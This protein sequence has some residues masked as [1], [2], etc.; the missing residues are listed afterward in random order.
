MFLS[1]RC[2][3][4]RYL[5][6]QYFVKLIIGTCHVRHSTEHEYCG[7]GVHFVSRD[8]QT[9]HTLRI[10]SDRVKSIFF[11]CVASSEAKLRKDPYSATGHER[12]VTRYQCRYPISARDCSAGVAWLT[13]C[14]LVSTMIEQLHAHLPI[15]PSLATMIIY[16]GAD[17]SSGVTK[18]QCSKDIS[19]VPSTGKSLRTLCFLNFITTLVQRHSQSRASG[20]G[21]CPATQLTHCSTPSVTNRRKRIYTP[22]T[23]FTRLSRMGKL[24]A[25]ATASHHT[26]MVRLTAPHEHLTTQPAHH[27]TIE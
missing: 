1:P 11:L 9:P 7:A 17:C 24:S 16:T 26:Q 25:Y 8:R 27:P 22:P 15:D 3:A 6:R 14:P 2:F 19:F 5:A 4:K 10:S 23:S 20:H 18:C 21:L 13:A 12:S